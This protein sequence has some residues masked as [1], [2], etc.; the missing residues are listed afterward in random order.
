MDKKSEEKVGFVVWKRTQKG[1]KAGEHNVLRSGKF[2]KDDRQRWEVEVK[3]SLEKVVVE[4]GEKCFH[5][6]CAKPA[7]VHEVFIQECPGKESAYDVDVSVI[8]TCGDEK[9]KESTTRLL[10]GMPLGW[11]PRQIDTVCRNCLECVD[12]ASRCGRCLGVWYCSREC[13]REHWPVHRPCCIL[14]S[15]HLI[16]CKSDRSK[17]TMHLP[18]TSKDL[19]EMQKSTSHLDK[20]EAVLKKHIPTKDFTIFIHGLN[21]CF[22]AKNS[23]AIL[24][25][26][27]GELIARFYYHHA[28]HHYS[29]RSSS[30]Q[31]TLKWGY[32]C[33]FDTPKMPFP[34]FPTHPVLREP[35]WIADSD[36]VDF[37]LSLAIRERKYD[38]FTEVQLGPDPQLC[39]VLG[40]WNLQPGPPPEL[41]TSALQ[42]LQTIAPSVITAMHNETTDPSLLPSSVFMTRT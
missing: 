28:T 18:L 30:K 26:G 1:T 33:S 2:F 36:I 42:H 22:G 31:I 3:A 32:A 25:H 37:A 21:V 4:A 39:F 12:K 35:E 10:K 5:F 23:G 16:P 13:Q 9:E 19:E 24:V 40:V 34:S 17:V 14:A 6:M 41:D 38:Y 7:S 20:A 29:N 27:R 15:A 11:L 8:A